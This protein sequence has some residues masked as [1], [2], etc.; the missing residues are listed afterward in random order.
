MDRRWLGQIAFVFPHATAEELAFFDALCELLDDVS[1]TKT[2]ADRI[3]FAPAAPL[4]A[5]PAMIVQRGD[6][7]HPTVVLDTAAPIDVRVDRFHLRSVAI[8]PLQPETKPDRQPPTASPRLAMDELA[9]RLDGHIVRIDHMGVN[10]P[11]RAVA[12]SAWDDLLR[13]LA[14]TTALYR[15]PTGEEWPFVVPATEEEFAG[16]ITQ[17]VAGREPKFELVYDGWAQCPVFQF[18]LETDQTRAQLE[19]LFPDPEGEAFPDLGDI[20]R[21]VYVAHPWPDLLI[22]FDLNYRSDGEPSVWDTGEWLVAAGGRIRPDAA[23]QGCG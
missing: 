8:A 16:E 6:V 3:V 21:T 20:F 19:A 12:R 11:T 10:V 18:S 2:D 5:L 22:R 17:F 23:D 15:Y 13:S 4:G 7:A 1:H 14:V 9:R